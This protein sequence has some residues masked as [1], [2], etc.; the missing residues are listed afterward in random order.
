MAKRQIPLFN[1]VLV[2]KIIPPYKTSAGILHSEKI[3]K[4]NYGE[5]LVGSA[6]CDTN[7]NSNS[8]KNGD[9]LVLSKGHATELRHGDKKSNCIYLEGSS[10][11]VQLKS[12]SCGP[13]SLKS[14]LWSRYLS[15]QAGA[16]SSDRENDLEDG[17]SGRS[18]DSVDGSGKED[19]EDLISEVGESEEY[20]EAEENSLGLGD[21]EA[22]QGGVKKGARRPLSQLFKIIKGTPRRSVISALDKYVEEGNPLGQAEIS[23]TLHNLR[24][25]RLHSMAL[26]FVEWL[27]TCKKIELGEWYYASRLNLMA[28]VHGLWQS[29][30]YFETIP[31]SFRN[32]LVYRTLLANYVA[33]VNLKKAEGVFN[34]IRDLGFP[35]TPYAC[36][37]LL[38]LYKR[39]NP[40]RIADV[41][42]MMEKENVQP[43]V[44]T[45]EILI[46]VKGRANDIPGIEQI[47]EMM[48]E[49]LEPDLRI[50]SLVAKAYV[51]AGLKDKAEATLEEI[52][53]E[54]VQENRAVCR[55]LLPLYAA[56]GK[57]DDVERIWNVCDANPH[58]AEC[59]A[60][61][62]AWGNLGKI[63]KAEE[64]FEKT[65][66]KWKSSTYYNTM[67]KVY[68][69][70]KLFAKGKELVNRMAQS[71]CRIGPLTWD[72]VVKLYVD[73]GEVEK[74]DSIL[75]KVT[76]QNKIRP[77]YCSFMA[78][79]DEYAKRGDIHNT[80]K[81]FRRLKEIGYVGRMKQYQILLQAYVNAKIPVY[82]FRDRM[83]AD[84]MYPNKAIAAQ[85]KAIN[86]SQNNLISELLD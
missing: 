61:I 48:K 30:K 12:Y 39:T 2:E 47:V 75:H 27:E 85:L 32:E 74:A 33:D 51:S 22:N 84:N 58:L 46:D 50:K 52:E 24:R 38:L 5:V 82:G 59:I 65:P 37:Q 72:A 4:L 28:K 81:I 20:D 42:Q 70:H 35:I 25:R 13:T 36:N 78:V 73:S 34:K 44:F 63:E 49:G 3:T 16:N 15:S 23:L 11:L 21:V 53:G 31:E 1:R 6:A 68:V 14:F 66:E 76:L 62:E 64:V 10:S 54:D 41:L 43:T 29:E 71:G 8:T 67:L 55:F 79:M 57:A 17:F 60:A 45:Y 9:T 83:K 19:D 69:E 80:E 7:G 56:L 86:A 26:Q 18:A 77:F 40:K